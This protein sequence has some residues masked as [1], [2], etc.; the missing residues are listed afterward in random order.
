MEISAR[1]ILQLLYYI[2]KSSANTDFCGGIMY[3]IKIMFF[4][5]RYHLRKYGV[6][7][8]GDVYYAMKRGPVASVALNLLHNRR[9]NYVNSAEA[10]IEDEVEAIDEYTVRIKEQNDDELSESVKEA[11]NFAL[12]HFGKFDQFKLS[13]IS[14]IYPEWKKCETELEKGGKKRLQLDLSLCFTD[15]DNKDL[16]KYGIKSDPFADS[17]EFLAEMREAFVG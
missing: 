1:K 16:Q 9:S 13:D 12:D 14:H 5:D 2:Q 6:T 4:A 17:P 15:P 7:A 11:V 10:G 3:L 8:S